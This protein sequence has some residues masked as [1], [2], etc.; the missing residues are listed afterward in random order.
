MV[1]GCG[2][3]VAW[4][5]CFTSILPSPLTLP[6]SDI[7]L[8]YERVQGPRLCSERER[9]KRVVAL[10]RAEVAQQAA[11]DA[12]E[13]AQE[14]VG[15][16]WGGPCVAA[17]HARP[18]RQLL[19][20]LLPLLHAM[21]LRQRRAALREAVVQLQAA[22]MTAEP[23]RP[24]PDA[25]CAA[26]S[27]LPGGAAM[28]ECPPEPEAPAFVP[29]SEQVLALEAVVVQADTA[30]KSAKA[31][32]KAAVLA[33]D[34]AES[35]ALATQARLGL[36]TVERHAGHHHRLPGLAGE[37]G[38]R[39]QQAYAKLW[40]R[41]LREGLADMRAAGR[42]L[43]AAAR[44]AAARGSGAVGDLSS[45]QRLAQAAADPLIAVGRVAGRLFAGSLGST[46]A[47]A[48]MGGLGVLRLGMGVVK[49]GMQLM[50]F[51][52][53]LYYLLAAPSDP[54]LAAA[55]VLPLSDG[56]RQRTAVALN[57][58]LGG[59]RGRGCAGLHLLLAVQCPAQ[60]CV[61]AHC[62]TLPLHRPQAC[63]S[64]LSSSSPSM[65]ASRGSRSGSWAYPSPTL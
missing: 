35:E 50:L 43:A 51:L 34:S 6:H 33:A 53:L 60:P 28:P 39:L 17:P 22:R 26:A 57:R 10:A 21:Q 32:H 11:H 3:V 37:V 61:P 23:G 65:A 58:A 29:L 1:V 45:L 5:R 16:R 44:G 41:Q 47:A 14:Q 2:V 7:R 36:C 63:S 55:G 20:A 62:P 54:L 52:A 18:G 48:L 31:A 56:G 4:A 12:K 13:H 64:P 40:R 15:Q 30:L 9:E 42:Q 25:H 59:G 8:L 49:F 19:T 38:G 24:A 27:G 46:T